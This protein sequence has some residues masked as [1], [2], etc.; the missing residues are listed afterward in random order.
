MLHALV[1]EGQQF[2]LIQ[3]KDTHRLREMF[4]RFHIKDQNEGH[5]V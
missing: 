1:I 2:L 3:S 4:L 5:F